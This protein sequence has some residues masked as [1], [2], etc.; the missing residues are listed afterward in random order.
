MNDITKLKK[1]YTIIQTQFI[2]CFKK[3][4]KK[5]NSINWNSEKEREKLYHIESKCDILRDKMKDISKKI[6]EI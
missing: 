1:Q 4:N 6:I 2:K 3:A 5:S